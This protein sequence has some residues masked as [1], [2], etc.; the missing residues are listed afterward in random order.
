MKKF[1]HALRAG[2]YSLCL[3]VTL[4]LLSSAVMAQSSVYNAPAEALQGSLHSAFISSNGQYYNQ[5]S[6]GTHTGF[7][8][9]WNANGIDALTD[10]YL[11]T[12]SNTYKNRMKTLLYGIKASNGNTYLNYFYDDMEWMAISCLRAYQHTGDTAYL[13]A[14]NVLWTDIQTGMHSG[15][16]YA[17]QWNKGTPN[18]FNAC[19]NAP[20]II[21]MCRLYQMNGN[22]T[23]LSRAQSIY[24][25]MKST[26]VNPTTGEVYDGYDA[27]TNT[28]NTNPGWIFSYNVGT[29]I[30]A[31]LE[32]Y[33]ITGNATYLND[34]I[35]T[36]E[37]AMTSK[38]VN[39]VFYTNETGG[40]DG[41]LFKGIFIRYFTLLAREGVLTTTNRARYV[42]AIKTSAASLN[43]RGINTANLLANPNWTTKPG[44]TTDYSTQLSAVMLLEAAATLDQVFFYKD[45][46]YGGYAIGFTP[47]SYTHNA[48]VARGALNDDL[49]SFTLP[50]GYSIT[51]YENDNYAGA[52]T[53]RT[54][55]TQWIGADWND[56]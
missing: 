44:A 6:G 5:T 10:G 42:N 51:L 3:P 34:A 30:G 25:W 39:G 56:R 20:A 52:S 46:N 49:T 36:A 50:D 14:V 31:A 11:R 45:L 13:N 15:R 55:S 37:H 4:L 8:Y 27:G 16:S 48:M 7:N 28:V 12:R 54:A 41:G 40:G 33:Q 22:A 35:L 17:I 43:G 47:G 21:F 29:W 24:A 2:Y 18:S 26:L 9:W 1:L 32:L 23:A 53:V 38:L 19:A